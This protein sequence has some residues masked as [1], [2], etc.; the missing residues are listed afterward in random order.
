M[1]SLLHMHPYPDDY[2]LYT[3]TCVQEFRDGG[4]QQFNEGHEGE[5]VKFR[6]YDDGTD[7]GHSKYGEKGEVGRGRQFIPVSQLCY[8]YMQGKQIYRV[9]C[10]SSTSHHLRKEK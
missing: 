7:G 10:S 4:H 9:H 1:S 6:T 8:I 3:M 2:L 5:L